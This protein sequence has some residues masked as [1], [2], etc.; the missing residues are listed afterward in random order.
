MWP[1]NVYQK[2]YCRPPPQHK[3]TNLTGMS[4]ST[5]TSDNM[6]NYWSASSVKTQRSSVLSSQ[7]DDPPFL[8][9]SQTSYRPTPGTIAV[10]A[11]SRGASVPPAVVDEPMVP[12]LEQDD[13][14][15][16]LSQSVSNIQQS[17]TTVDEEHEE[18][19]KNRSVTQDQK[20]TITQWLRQQVKALL[21]QDQRQNNS[22]Q[23]Q[24]NPQ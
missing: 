2:T 8:A 3:V 24:I 6:V 11:A 22:S 15:L 12:D 21:R 14:P 18:E 13:P 19:Q 4:D 16:T 9:Q 23:Q 10:P 5:G 7:R 20:V 1:D 17:L